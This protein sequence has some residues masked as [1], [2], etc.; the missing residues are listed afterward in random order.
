MID[1]QTFEV[2]DTIEVGPGYEVQAPSGDLMLRAGTAVIFA[3]GTVIETGCHV[4][5]EIDPSLQVSP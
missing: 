5:V 3:N 1:T 2:C 4:R